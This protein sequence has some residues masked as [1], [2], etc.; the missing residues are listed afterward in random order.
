MTVVADIVTF[1]ATGLA[2][3][4]FMAE[5]AFHQYVVI[6]V[7]ERFTANEAFVVFHIGCFFC[8]TCA[9]RQADSQKDCKYYW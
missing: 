1:N 3:F 9:G 7:F 6:E 2:W 4:F 5:D 8:F